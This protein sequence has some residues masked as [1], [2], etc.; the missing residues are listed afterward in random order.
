MALTRRSRPVRRR[1][2]AQPGA[3]RGGARSRAPGFIDCIGVMFAGREEEPTR[4]LHEVLQPG[5]GPATSAS[6]DRRA[7]CSRS[8]LD[9]RRRRAC[10]RLRRRG[11][12]RASEHGAGAG[13]PG[14]GGD[15]G[16]VRARHGGGVR[17]RLRGLGGA[18]AAGERVIIT[19]RAGTR[20]AFSAPSRRR[21]PAPICAGSIRRARRRPSRWVR[22][23]APD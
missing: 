8:G 17:R 19:A 2:V 1:P 12:A 6:R 22:R 9:Q 7:G 11:A 18:G 5:D 15:A 21:P 23:R 13:D 14:R 3:G 16:S 10:A 20:P 4:L